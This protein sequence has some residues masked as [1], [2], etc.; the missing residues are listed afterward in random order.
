MRRDQMKFKKTATKTRAI[1][2]ST[3]IPRGGICL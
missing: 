1:N 2:F 3:K